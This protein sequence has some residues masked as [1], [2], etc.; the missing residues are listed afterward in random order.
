MKCFWYQQEQPLYSVQD[1]T[2]GKKMTHNNVHTEEEET[3]LLSATVKTRPAR[4][5]VTENLW[6]GTVCALHSA[7]YIY[8]YIYIYTYIWG[9]FRWQR[10]SAAENELSW[11]TAPIMAKTNNARPAWFLTMPTVAEYCGIIHWGAVASLS[12]LYDTLDYILFI[13]LCSHENILLNTCSHVP[14]CIVDRK[15]YN[16]RLTLVLETKL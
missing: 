7:T 4:V 13:D 14:V 5:A 11:N 6:S 2:L 8:I 15:L 3:D 9:L 12:V 1:A 16:G 10:R